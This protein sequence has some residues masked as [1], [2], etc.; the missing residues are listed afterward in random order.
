TAPYSFS[1]GGP[2]QP[3]GKFGNLAAG[4]YTV[5]LLDAN[6]CADTI[7]VQ[8]PEE[9]GPVINHILVTDATCCQN[10]G[11]LFIQASGGNPPLM[12][13]IGGSFQLSNVFPNLAPGSYTVTV[14]DQNGCTVQ[15][16][17]QITN[18]GGPV[19][20]SVIVVESL[21]GMNTGS[22]SIVASG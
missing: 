7:M 20:E 12:Y 14:L 10:N 11:S 21:C 19:I 22:V 6:G 18:I 8:V 13:S 2:Y 1:I 5:Y 16:V 17:V 4:S 15:Q 3:I 9:D